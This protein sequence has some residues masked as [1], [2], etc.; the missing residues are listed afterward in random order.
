MN[1]E[2]YYFMLFY[3]FIM[4]SSTI[5]FTRGSLFMFFMCVRLFMLFIRESVFTD[6]T[7][8]RLFMLFKFTRT[9]YKS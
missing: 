5:V 8:E 6:F 3:A 1:E 7:K 9:V 2:E 4:E